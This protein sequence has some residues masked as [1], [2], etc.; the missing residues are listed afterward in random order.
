MAIAIP[1][2]SGVREAANNSKCRSNLKQLHTA[3]IAYATGNKERF[4][5]LAGTTNLQSLIDGG[6]IKSESKLGLCPGHSRKPKLPHS[7]YA[8]GPDLDGSK[9]LSSA[10]INS[11]TIILEDDDPDNHKAGKNVI[12]LDGSF[13]QKIEL[14]PAQKRELLSSNDKGMLDEE[15]INLLGNSPSVDDIADLL[16]AGADPNAIVNGE[17]MLKTAVNWGDLSIIIKILENDR[18]DVNLQN[19]QDNNYTPL[20][21]AVNAGEM[22]IV[23]A[24]LAK[25]G[26]NVNL[27]DDEGYTPLHR[28]MQN[29][30][31]EI[32]LAILVKDGVNINLQDDEGYTPLHFAVDAGEPEIALAILAKDG[33]DLTIRDNKNLTVLALAEKYDEP[34]IVAA[35]R[36]YGK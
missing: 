19:E 33:L 15:L 32:A 16:E 7:S 28:V 25:D 26:V 3:I 18:T 5:N 17:T 34:E 22:E 36:G 9:K 1:L 31:P 2:I 11:E 12:R 13:S 14:T 30:E 23:K 29:K 24:I 6:Y 4:P 20:H 21:Y 10:G 27:Q 8:G 35:I